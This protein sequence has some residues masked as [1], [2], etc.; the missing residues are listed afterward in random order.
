M[1]FGRIVNK[2]YKEIYNWTEPCRRPRLQTQLLFT[3]SPNCPIMMHNRKV[4][5]MK[6][7]KQSVCHERLGDDLYHKTEFTRAGSHARLLRLSED[8]RELLRK[9][10][11]EMTLDYLKTL[12][13]YV[14]I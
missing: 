11:I 2:L 10:R 1:S 14:E 6:G 13:P 5:G 3:A 12:R 4:A 9:E 7:V 8:L